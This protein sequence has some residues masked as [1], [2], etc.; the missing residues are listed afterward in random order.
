MDLEVLEQLK[1]HLKSLQK[2][3]MFGADFNLFGSYLIKK[4]KIDD[5]YVCFLS[6]LPKNFQRALNV[7]RFA[8][9]PSV[10]YYKMLFDSIK[11]K[12]FLNNSVYLVNSE[13]ALNCIQGLIK[14]ME[15]DFDYIEKNL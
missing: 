12:F 1:H 15:K 14:N 4:N 5:V 2:V 11:G 8:K 7:T 6:L 3:I 10:V 9:V 13:K